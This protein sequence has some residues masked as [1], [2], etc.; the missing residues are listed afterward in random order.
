M[1]N[2]GEVVVSCIEHRFETLPDP[3]PPWPSL[4][5]RD[6]LV[7]ESDGSGGV[8]P[9][10]TA[11]FDTNNEFEITIAAPPGEQFLV[12]PPARQAF[13]FDVYLAWTALGGGS[14]R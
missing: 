7:D 13:S 2:L 11:N 5:V 3:L 4:E 14:G 6:A 10:V 8:L 1:V 12:H 9:T